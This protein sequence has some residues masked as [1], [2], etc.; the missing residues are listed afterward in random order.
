MVDEARISKEKMKNMLVWIF[1]LCLFDA[2]VT[3]F[4]IQAGYIR[5][6]NPLMKEVYHWNRSFFYGCK[7]FLPLLLLWIYPQLKRRKVVNGGILL[8]LVAYAAVTVYHFFWMLLAL[9]GS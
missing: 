8:C 7:L 4:G 6:L 2:V 9:K 5:E 3:D 1:V